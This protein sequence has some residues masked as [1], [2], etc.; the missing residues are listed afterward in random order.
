MF[1][2]KSLKTG[3]LL[4]IS[5]TASS[6][7]SGHYHCGEHIEAELVE[8]EDGDTCGPWLTTDRNIAERVMAWEFCDGTLEKPSFNSFQDGTEIVEVT[9]T[10]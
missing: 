5:A 9:L 1:G 8:R 10:F 2:I 7:Y 3:N 4:V 6:D